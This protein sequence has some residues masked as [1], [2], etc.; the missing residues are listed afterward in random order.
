MAQI[1][2]VPQWKW[3]LT[4][5]R[6]STEEEDHVRLVR[7]A[8]AVAMITITTG[9]YAARIES[10]LPPSNKVIKKAFA[11]SWIYGLVPPST[12]ATSAMC[13]DGVSIVETQLSFVNQ[14]VSLLT[15]GIYTP[16]QI[17]VTCAEKRS[18]SLFRPGT[19]MT[20]SMNAPREEV[21][22]IFSRAADAAVKTG[23]P[24]AVYTT[25]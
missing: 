21:I 19:E 8:V 7:S 9:C 1:P 20:V 13:P 25:E 5:L 2:Y 11:S 14:V 15:L 18:A 24:V 10:G 4:R 6:H 23:Q 16:M 12:V 17:V 22:A 3:V